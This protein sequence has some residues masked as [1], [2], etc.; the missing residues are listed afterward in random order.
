MDVQVELRR[1]RRDH[2]RR[3][4]GRGPTERREEHEAFITYRDISI[5]F[6]GRS[7]TELTFF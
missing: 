6:F 1:K 7:S 4:E 3:R 2:D 5:I